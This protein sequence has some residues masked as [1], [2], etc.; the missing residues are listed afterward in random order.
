MTRT[1]AGLLKAFRNAPRAPAVVLYLSYAGFGA[2]CHGAHFGL[3]P[4]LY[5]VVFVFALPAQVVLVDEISHHAPVWTA[6]LAVTLT[7]VRLLPMT[8]ALMPYLRARRRPRLADYAAAH[9]IAVTVWIESMRRIPSLPRAIRQPYFSGLA[10]ILV[11]V[12]VSGTISGYLAAGGLP[13]IVAAGLILL[14]P[15]YFFLGLMGTASKAAGYAP[16]LLGICSAPLFMKLAPGFDLVLTGLVAG[17]ASFLI[18]RRGGP[19]AEPSRQSPGLAES[20]DVH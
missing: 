4:A 20:S 18:F 8:V 15:V 10:I 6:A 13:P 3:A 7:G 19:A 2:L 17:T 14:T 9:F 5:T 11:G 12:S 16:I 1:K